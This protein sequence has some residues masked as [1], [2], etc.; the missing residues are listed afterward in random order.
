[1]KNLVL[2]EK[3]GKGELRKFLN[4]SITTMPS[5]TLKV[6]KKFKYRALTQLIERKRKFLVKL[7]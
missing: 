3:K 2:N 1:M 5:Q 7:A 6:S 4:F